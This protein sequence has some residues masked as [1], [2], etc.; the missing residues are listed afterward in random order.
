M[1]LT[2][3]GAAYAWG[4]NDEGQLGDGTTTDRTTPVLVSPRPSASL[5][6]RFRQDIGRTLDQGRDEGAAARRDRDVNR[7]SPSDLG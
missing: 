2:T 5:G 6:L 4:L 1:G 7:P 3:S